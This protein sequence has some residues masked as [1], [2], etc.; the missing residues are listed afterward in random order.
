VKNLAN[1]R[2][3]LYFIKKKKD[4]RGDEETGTSNNFCYLK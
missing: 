1:D 3:T 4:K 2:E